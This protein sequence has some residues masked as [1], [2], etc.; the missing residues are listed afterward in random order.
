MRILFVSQFFYPENF[1][2]NDLAFELVKR[3]HEVTVLTGQPN[4][5]KGEFYEGYGNFKKQHEIV[6]GVDIHRVLTIPR[7][8]GKLMLCLNYISF[9]VMGG[10]RAK[11]MKNKN[12]D[13]IYAFGTSP[14]T[15]VIPAIAMKKRSGAKVIVNV[16]DLWP[17]NVTAITG[18]KNKILLKLLDKLVDS[19]YNS[20]DVI[21][22]TSRSFVSAI[23]SRPGLKEKRKVG[24]WPQYA[25]VNKSEE[26]RPDLLPEGVFHIVFTGNVGEGQG[27]DMVVEAAKI[28]KKREI[29][30]LCFDIVG[31]GRA[32][33]SLEDKVREMELMEYVRF[34]GSFP[35][36]EV[37][38]ILN[39]AGAA[40]LILNDSPIF[41]KTIPAKL[42]TYL[43]CGCPIL[44][45]V[46]GESKKLIVNNELGICETHGLAE[47]L[48]E[49]AVKMMSLKEEELKRFSDNALRI[50][51]EE[52]N[53]DK[54][55]DKL[56]WFME[57]LCQK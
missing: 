17:D 12:F 50:S 20:C 56:L 47:G 55:I 16:Q 52:F 36:N 48:S 14:I 24:Y 27:L 3:G 31:D 28:L 29:Q 40:L 57:R 32:R 6:N 34:H 23:K 4:Y 54:L 10:L 7:K 11:F 13:V 26:K 38:G 42:Q 39:S 22:G 33:V 19:I 18:L 46:Q 25:V 5:P 37:P 8:T 2:I 15:Q 49:A 9:I 35:E 1:R 43:A 53:K 41:E 30:G 45:Y 21:L 44:G 51:K